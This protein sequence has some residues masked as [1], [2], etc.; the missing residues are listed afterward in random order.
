MR[1]SFYRL[2]ID[3]IGATPDSAILSPSITLGTTIWR[4][5]MKT[6]IRLRFAILPVLLG[7]PFAQLA[8]AADLA[9]KDERFLKNAAQGGMAEAQLG[10]LG[11][12][13]ATKQSVKEFAAMMA[14]DHGKANQELKSLASQKGVE[15]P[16]DV[17]IGQKMAREKLDRLSGAEFDKEFVQQMIKDHKKTIDLFEDASKDAKDSDV[18]S[19][20]DKTLPTLR[21]HLQQAEALKKDVGAE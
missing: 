17:E 8:T 18:K 9:G 20:A 5:A 2:L 1:I 11:K 3:S 15:L 7:L 6:N 19:F 16:G 13:K 14:A 10:E 21:G 12:S 4:I